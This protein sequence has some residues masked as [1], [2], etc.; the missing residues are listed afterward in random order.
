MTSNDFGVKLISQLA[1]FRHESLTPPS[2]ITSKVMTLHLPKPQ[3]WIVCRKQLPLFKAKP[4]SDRTIL[5]MQN[6]VTHNVHNVG[7][8]ETVTT[9]LLLPVHQWLVNCLIW[10][11]DVY[12]DLHRILWMTPWI[13]QCPLHGT[14]GKT[15]ECGHKYILFVLSNFLCYFHQT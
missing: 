15:C 7:L 4:L 12:P 9:C 1:T 10:V 3:E 11:W 2:K 14:S 6:I 8:L 5:L 13:K